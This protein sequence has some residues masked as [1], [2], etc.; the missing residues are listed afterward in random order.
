MNI[1]NLSVI[2]EIYLKVKQLRM[3]DVKLGIIIVP[4]HSDY[5]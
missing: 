3:S 5:L 4:I 1:E 2:L